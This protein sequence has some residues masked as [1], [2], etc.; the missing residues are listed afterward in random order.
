MHVP[1]A[2]SRQHYATVDGSVGAQRGDTFWVLWPSVL[3]KQGLSLSRMLYIRSMYA[4]LSLDTLQPIHVHF[5]G[6]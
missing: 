6:I 1:V 2:D 4:I 5:P 3:G